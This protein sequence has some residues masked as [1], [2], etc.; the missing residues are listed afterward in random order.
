VQHKATRVEIILWRWGKQGRSSAVAVGVH[1]NR[2][3]SA[4]MQYAPDNTAAAA[5]GF[6][7][8]YRLYMAR[9][10]GA[11]CGCEC[12]GGDSLEAR[13]QIGV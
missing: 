10:L 3:L 8:L 12:A 6:C 4:C 9:N 11:G 13:V 2:V 1:E 5:C 7:C